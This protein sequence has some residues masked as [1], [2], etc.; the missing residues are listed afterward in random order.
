MQDEWGYEVLEKLRARGI[1]E[2]SIDGYRRRH[3]RDEYLTPLYDGTLE[4][5]DR[6]ITAI[7]S[8]LM[9]QYDSVLAEHSR[10][11]NDIA[12][13]LNNFIQMVEQQKET[14]G[15][16]NDNEEGSVASSTNW[17]GAGGY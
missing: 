8:K 6:R 15:D 10:M 14:S 11:I 2:K 4:I 1:K 3:E 7:E 17:H 13:V 16:K 5:M 9:M 12:T